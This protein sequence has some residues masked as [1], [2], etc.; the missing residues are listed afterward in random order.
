MILKNSF[1]VKILKPINI[2]KIY[3]SIPQDKYYDKLELS[4]ILFDN[5]QSFYVKELDIF[6]SNNNDYSPNIGNYNEIQVQLLPKFKS[7][8][9]IIELNFPFHMNREQIM[10]TFRTQ[11]NIM[12]IKFNH[13]INNIIIVFSNLEDYND[14]LDT[15][16]KNS[17][18]ML[19]IDI[20]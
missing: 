14:L 2:K 17:F 6:T 16:N 15:S 10:H 19:E 5:N 13:E 7:K 8:Q 3:Y 4:S 12:N 9:C 20:V 1:I 11:D 18:Y